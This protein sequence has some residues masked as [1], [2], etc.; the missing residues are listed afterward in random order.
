M[1]YV[2]ADDS[3]V[4]VDVDYFGKRRDPSRP[5]PGPFEELVTG[6]VSLRIW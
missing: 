3:P 4:R 1:P 6:S 2:N 5:T